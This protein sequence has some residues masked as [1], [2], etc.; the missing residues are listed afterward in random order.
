MPIYKSIKQKRAEREQREADAVA[1]SERDEKVVTLRKQG[2]SLREIG[3]MFGLTRE[4]VRQIV[5]T[6]NASASIAERVPHFNSAS[7]SKKKFPK[8]DLVKALL[9][10]GKT[11]DEISLELGI[12]ASSLSK[13][14]ALLR[15]EGIVCSKPQKGAKINF[16]VA[17]RMRAAGATL[18]TIADRFDCTVPSVHQ[19]LDKH[20]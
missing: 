18:Q 12:S 19:L 16:E 13:V 1:R 6:Y 7:V 10:D 20:K 8:K 4:R 3:E 14:V 2:L 9:E 17:R 11:L 5:E 15:K